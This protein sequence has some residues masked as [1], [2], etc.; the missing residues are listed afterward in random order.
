MKKVIA[1]VVVVVVVGMI[2]FTAKS[3]PA[4]N[5][6]VKVG[7]L[8]IMAS[9][10]PFQIAAE[11]GFFEEEGVVIKAT[12]L[13]SSNLL[14]DAM[15]RGDIDITPEISL[16]PYMTAELTAPGKMQIFSVTDLTKEEPFD[17]LLVKQDSNIHSLT[18]LPGKKIGVPPGTTSTNLLTLFL[19]S[20]GVD[21]TNI[22]FI[23]LAPALQLQGLSAGSID[24]LFAYDPLIA[25]GT[26][27][28]NMRV[29]YGSA[30]AELVDHNPLGGGLL[31]KAFVDN[32]PEAARRAVN[33]INKA[34]DFIETN[35]DE[36]RQIMA[37]TFN[38]TDP[39]IINAVS[40]PKNKYLDDIDMTLL[41]RLM[42]IL[43]EAGELTKKPD[44]TKALYQ[45]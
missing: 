31:T 36:T 43:V 25:I 19:E 7:Y 4:E 15:L 40:L 41:E 22:Q 9:K 8:Q 33:A 35:P 44:L 10:L 21:T 37:K 14:L 1:V 45:P 28:Q 5:Y 29:L 39:N 11:K 2:I 18:E 34:Y 3:K 17:S 32:H 42:T 6:V 30:W 26:K 38:L 23:Q 20:K 12:E 24:V 13:Q 16:F 27:S